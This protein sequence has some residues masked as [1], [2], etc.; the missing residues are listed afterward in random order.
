MSVYKRVKFTHDRHVPCT[1]AVLSIH[2]RQTDSQSAGDCYDIKRSRE[3]A[4]IINHNFL[5]ELS[6]A[7]RSSPVRHRLL[8]VETAAHS[9]GGAENAGLENSLE[10]DELRLKQP[11]TSSSIDVNELSQHFVGLLLYAKG[12]NKH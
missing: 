9:V 8:K 3:V 1:V 11:Q 2:S 7:V 4:D 5:S 6:A 10:C 12:G